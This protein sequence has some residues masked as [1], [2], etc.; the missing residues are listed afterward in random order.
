[1]VVYS[2]KD[3]GVYYVRILVDWWECF[4]VSWF[5]IDKVKFD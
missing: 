2:V 3:I 1:M 4:V 5:E